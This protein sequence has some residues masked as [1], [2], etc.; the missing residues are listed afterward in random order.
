[1]P[2]ERFIESYN[3]NSDPVALANEYDLTVSAI[4]VRIRRLGLNKKEEEYIWK[5]QHK[6]TGLFYCSRKGRFKNKITNLSGKGNF[7]TSLKDVEKIFKEQMNAVYINEAQVKKYN[8]LD[9]IKESN[10]SFGKAKKEDF[11]IKKY[12]LKEMEE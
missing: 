10:S 8:C 5:I 12:I 7:Y 2:R 6:P 9:N 11:I 3:K 1:M 4:R